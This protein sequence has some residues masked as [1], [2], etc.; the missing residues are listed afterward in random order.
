MK[1]WFVREEMGEAASLNALYYWWCSGGVDRSRKGYGRTHF[2]WLRR[3]W[4]EIERK[5]DNIIF[6]VSASLIV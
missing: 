6:R 2:W 5:K 3:E 4:K 1:G